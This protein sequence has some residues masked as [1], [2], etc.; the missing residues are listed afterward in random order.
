MLVAEPQFEKV[1]WDTLVPNGWFQDRG[2][3][4]IWLS[5]FRVARVVAEQA[6]SSGHQVV[7][8]GDVRAVILFGQFSYFDPG[9][10]TVNL[11]GTPEPTLVEFRSE[12]AG[13]QQTPKGVWLLL[14]TP[15]DVDGRP[16][17]EVE[18]RRRIESAAGLL[19]AFGGFNLVYEAG[20]ENIYAADGGRATSASPA[21]INPYTQPVPDVS[22]PYL[23]RI[24]N[25]SERIRGLPPADGNRVT[26]ALHW[27]HL[28]MH[29]R[30]VDAF[31]KR[32]I[33]LEVLCMPDGANV[34]PVSEALAAAYGVTYEEARDTYRIGRLA[35]LRARI[36][37]DGEPLPIHSKLELYFDAVFYDALMQLLGEPCDR[38]AANV[39]ATEAA[40]FWGSVTPATPNP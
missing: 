18:V 16:G 1:G 24:A 22:E 15:Y 3:S 28:A 33:A 26:L 36:V 27:F 31:L 2:K 14:L 6:L 10:W 32:W 25:V 29:D 39:L 21:L 19:A 34:R 38:R 5:S 35:D 11:P 20:P 17:D 12:G 4:S 9:R 7:D 40:E 13:L 8:L 37:H 30:G 23:A